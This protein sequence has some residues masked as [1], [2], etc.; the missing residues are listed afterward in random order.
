MLI[1]HIKLKIIK[2]GLNMKKFLFL[3][4]FGASLI[5]AELTLV[6]SDGFKLYGWL[7]KPKNMKEATPV[8]LFVHQF[9]A[10]HTIW[11]AIAKEFNTKGYAT[12]KVDLRG[13]GMSIMQHAK[14]NR[15][16]T[17]FKLSH[18]RE[19]MVQSNEKVKFA[20]IPK[21]LSAW[22]EHISEDASLDMDNLYFFGSSLGA[23]AIL[24]LLN[25]YEA[26]GY[27][28]ISTGRLEEFAQDTEM[29]LS[30]SISKGLFIAAKDDPLGAAQRS[31]EYTQ[32]SINSTAII[33]S[34]D[35]HGTV[36]LPQ[37]DSYIFSF[38]EN[39]R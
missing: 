25:E 35:G 21:D 30:T 11:D 28:V 4:I 15:A 6:S 16:I 39:I 37:V 8:I 26:K 10:D 24:P 9:G 3:L 13:H 12:L 20:N 36:L 19:A 29:A 5:G 31:I 17:D 14:E 32:K 1:L 2:K 34:G 27:V 7:D 18:I 38:M 22:I 33:V 23:G